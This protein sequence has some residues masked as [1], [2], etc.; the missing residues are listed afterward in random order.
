MK[1]ILVVDDCKAEQKLISALLQH[2]GYQAIATDSAE[3][4]LMW[5]QNNTKPDSIVLDVIMPG[6]DGLDFCRQ[7]RKMPEFQDIPIVFCSQKHRDLD[8]F[9]ALRQGGN[10]YI[11]KPFAPNELVQVVEKYLN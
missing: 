4:A 3:S 2:A 7:L 5:L 6:I 11:S 8:K 9:W 10:A 1:T